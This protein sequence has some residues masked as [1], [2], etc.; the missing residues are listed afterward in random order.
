M[1]R[2]IYGKDTMSCKI[3]HGWILKNVDGTNK[4]IDSTEKC[5][6]LTDK[7]MWK[8]P[9]DVPNGVK[10]GSKAK[11]EPTVSYEEADKYFYAKYL[12]HRLVMGRDDSFFVQ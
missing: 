8:L 12:V 5:I 11:T 6:V 2:E 1:K 4:I 3:Y 9:I 7:C 10:T